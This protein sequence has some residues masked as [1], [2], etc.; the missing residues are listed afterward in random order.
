MTRITSIGLS[1][2]VGERPNPPKASE[3]MQLTEP[4]E[5]LSERP[6]PSVATMT[7]AGASSLTRAKGWRAASRAAQHG[8]EA[9][10]RRDEVFGLMRQERDLARGRRETALRMRRARIGGAD[11]DPQEAMPLDMRHVGAARLRRIPLDAFGVKFA[12]CHLERGI[13]ETHFLG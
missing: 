6:E 4:S 11:V 9:E 13:V 2:Y 3:E 8:W 1:E 12:A 7:P 10:R 5:R